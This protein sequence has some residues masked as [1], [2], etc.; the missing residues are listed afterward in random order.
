M[1]DK[2]IAAILAFPLFGGWGAHKFYL[3]QV[4]AG[5]VYLAFG[6]RTLNAAMIQVHRDLEEAGRLAGLTALGTLRKIVVPLVAAAVFSSWFWIALLSYREVTM[7]LVLYA[8][9]NDVIATQVWMMWREGQAGE[10]SALGTVLVLVLAGLM[11]TVALVYKQAVLA[12]ASS[13]EGAVVR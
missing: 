8:Q 5:I 10:V 6:S 13:V 2:N 7:A 1:K 3:G 11:G 4:G 12:R 9:Q